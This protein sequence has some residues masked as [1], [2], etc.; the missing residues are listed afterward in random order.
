M[1]NLTGFGLF[2]HRAPYGYR[3]RIS[4]LVPFAYGGRCLLKHVHT[5]TNIPV[6]AQRTHAAGAANVM[7]TPVMAMGTENLR[8]PSVATAAPTAAT[9]KPT[10]SGSTFQV[11]FMSF[12]H[13]RIV[14][15]W[16][17]RHE[18]TDRFD[19]SFLPLILIAYGRSVLHHSLQLF[20]GIGRVSP[21]RHRVAIGTNGPKVLDGINFVSFTTVGKGDQVMNVAVALSYWPIGFSEI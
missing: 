21:V 9:A 19:C 4:G 16:A 10:Q 17:I 2:L 6:V 14:R 13:V 5:E 7:A 1:P 15:E 18:Q 3:F 11:V 20:N 8:A 12:H